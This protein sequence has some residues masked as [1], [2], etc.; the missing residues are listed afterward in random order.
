METHDAKAGDT[1]DSEVEAVLEFWFG[2]D[3]LDPVVSLPYQQRWF[4]A[5][6]AL[7]GEVRQR[8]AP[9]LARAAAGALGVWLESAHGRL[10]MIL[11]FD[12][13]SR[14]IH[15]GTA[16]AFAYDGRA[17]ELSSQGI[18]NGHDRALSVVERLFFYMPFQHAESREVQARGVELFEALA[19]ERAPEHMQRAALSGAEFA[20]QHAAIIAEFG[21]F[22]HRNRVLERASTEQEAAFLRDGGPSFGQ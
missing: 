12:Q 2:P 17:L 20:R 5:S 15:R 10:A 21:R 9:L 4:L 1:P 16:G 22:P 18:E 8:F 6:D 7:D 13:L 11:L 19:A 3:P 14:N